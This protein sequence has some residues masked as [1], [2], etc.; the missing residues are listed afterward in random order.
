MRNGIRQNVALIQSRVV[1]GCWRLLKVHLFPTSETDANFYFVA[2]HNTTLASNW[3]HR[4]IG[5]RQT[6]A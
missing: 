6:G 2:C 1:E 3:S 4:S 5:N